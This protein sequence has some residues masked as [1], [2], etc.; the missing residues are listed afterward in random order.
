MQMNQAGQWLECITGI[1]ALPC[2]YPGA[3]SSVHAM[4]VQA[5]ALAVAAE[6]LQMKLS[7]AEAAMQERQA[8]LAALQAR[9]AEEGV[10]LG[11]SS[12]QV[13]QRSLIICSTR[14]PPPLMSTCNAHRVIACNV[15]HAK[16]M[17][18]VGVQGCTL[19]TALQPLRQQELVHCFSGLQTVS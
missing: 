4:Q 13:W 14:P 8:K 19:Q 15:L 16:V 9:L 3:Q 2:V 5:E 17:H 12:A 18:V 1:L 10:T 11:D 6:E 7:E